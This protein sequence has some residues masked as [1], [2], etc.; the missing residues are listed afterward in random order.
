MLVIMPSRMQFIRCD[1]GWGWD[2]E[3]ASPG[4]GWCKPALGH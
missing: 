1:G 3:L 4:E 2:G